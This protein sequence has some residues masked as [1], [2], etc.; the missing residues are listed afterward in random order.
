MF[1][2]HDHRSTCNSISLYVYSSSHAP[3]LHHGDYGIQPTAHAREYDKAATQPIARVRLQR[4]WCL[5]LV[6]VFI[7]EARRDSDHSTA[8]RER[9]LAECGLC[10]RVGD[11]CAHAFVAQRDA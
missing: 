4:L 7:H 6:D 9:A 11:V 10:E 8:R 5:L 2:D 3:G 1:A